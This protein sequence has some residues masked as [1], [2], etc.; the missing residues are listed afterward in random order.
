MK[1]TLFTL[2][3]FL[4]ILSMHQKAFSQ[5]LHT[6]NFNVIIDTTKVLKWN[7]TPSFRYRNLKEDFLELANTAD[8]SFRFGNHGFTIANKIEYSIFGS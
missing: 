7:F 2:T 6:E 4:C 8:V 1:K 3:V 5:V